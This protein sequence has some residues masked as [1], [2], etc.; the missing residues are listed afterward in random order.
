MYTS[1]QYRFK[2]THFLLII[3]RVCEAI[4]TILASYITYPSSEEEWLEIA[5]HFYSGWQLPNSI[6]AIDRKHVPILHPPG[7]G[8]EYFNNK[9]FFS[10]VV[11]T[12]VGPNAE[13]VFANGGVLRNTVFYHALEAKQLNIPGPK[14]LPVND[15]IVEEWDTLVSHYFVGVDAFSL[16]ENVMKPYAKRGISEEQR[17]FNSRLSRA[18]IVRENLF[19]ILS[20][21]FR[22]FHS[23]LGVKPK[24]AISIVHSCLALPNF[25]IN[26]CPTVYTPPGPW[27]MKMKSVKLL[28]VNGGKL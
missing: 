3:P 22:I 5:K 15:A 2:R 4:P 1:L 10:I 6:G 26:K 27:I 9:G 23:T 8:S 20:D 21:K 7:T 19:G 17:A 25:R 18:R 16:T 24:N 13:F 12:V 11:M 14:H 28:L